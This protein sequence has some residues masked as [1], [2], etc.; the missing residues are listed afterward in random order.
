MWCCEVVRRIH[1]ERMVGSR[2]LR[3][4]VS[5][6][7]PKTK[8]STDSLSHTKIDARKL[9]HEQ[10]KPCQT[11]TSSRLQNVLLEDGCPLLGTLVLLQGDDLTNRFHFRYHVRII[12]REIV[13]GAD[14]F[15][16]FVQTTTFSQPSWRLRQAPDDENYGDGEYE[17]NR[18]WRPPRSWTIEEREAEIDPVSL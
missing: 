11:H 17:L 15:E 4:E 2:R 12:R 18:N 9:I 16:R 6:R 7:C 10:T 1:Q 14:H 3:L 5:K 8:I 13:D